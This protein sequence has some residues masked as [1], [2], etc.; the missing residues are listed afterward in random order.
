MRELIL[1]TYSP[2]SVIPIYNPNKAAVASIISFLNSLILY[3]YFI[4]IALYVSLE[5]VRVIQAQFIA[6]DIHMYDPI[7][8]K[9]AKVKSAGLNEELGQV[10]AIFSDKTGTL[11]CNQMDF[12]RVSIA[13][14]AYGI[15][16]TEV[17][18]AAKQLGIALGGGPS[19]RDPKDNLL[20]FSSDR[21]AELQGSINMMDHNNNYGHDNNP[22]REKGFTFYDP[23]LLG[24]N[25][26]HEPSSQN[27]QFFMQILAL[28]HTTIPDGIPK[29]PTSMRYRAESPDEAALVVAAKQFGFYFYKR[30]PTMLHVRETVSPNS[31]PVDQVYQLLNVLEFSIARKQMSVIVR[32]PNGRL[33][34]LSK[35]VDFVMLQRV[36]KNKSGF[37]KETNK[38]WKAFGEVGLRT[39]MVAYKQ[40]D[41]EEYTKWQA[42]YAEAR[43]TAGHER[44][45]RTEEL[46]DEIEQ[47]LTVAGGTGVED[48]LQ[49]GVPK[50]IDRFARAGIKIWVLTGD[51]EQKAFVGRKLSEALDL[52][53]TH[54][55]N[56]GESMSSAKAV[57]FNESLQSALSRSLSRTSTLS[58]NLSK[59]SGRHSRTPS[60]GT[61]NGF[62]MMPL[63]SNHKHTVGIGDLS[64]RL[65]SLG[66]AADYPLR[67]ADQHSHTIKYAL[68][69]D[70][71]SLAFILAEEELQE[72][73]LQVCIN[74]A[75]V[76]CYRVSPRQ[77]AQVTQLV[78]KG[79]GQKRLCV[80][81]GDGVYDVGMIQAT[82]VGVGIAGVEGAQAAMV[83]DYA[84]AQFR[85]LERLLLVHGRRCYR[86]ISLMDY[87]PKGSIASSLQEASKQTSHVVDR[88]MRHGIALGIARGMSFLHTQC[89]PPIVHGDVKPNNV[90]FDAD[91]E[92][93]LS[94][95]GLTAWTRTPVDP[96]PSSSSAGSLGYVSPEANESGKL[97]QEAD[98]YSFG[99]VL[100]EL[101]TRRRPAVFNVQDEDIAKRVKRMLQ[102]GEITEVFDP[103][104]VD[105]GPES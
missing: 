24:G 65:V 72:R 100:L 60:A 62:Q 30:T 83:A 92:P 68:V 33:L 103:A 48:K 104:S 15:G 69:I 37:V 91:L 39:L 84:I 78:R 10:D 16:T 74:R 38:H 41:E 59:H 57:S 35:G 8:N 56:L 93:H 58:R 73:F 13:G 3:G 88:P 36:D 45:L 75:S 19:P 7:T 66:D 21:K 11:T 67:K 81:I 77:K 51:K 6:T 27:I 32:F 101:P 96:T 44:D 2:P 12:F 18:R 95:F 102:L 50:A 4:P 79:L 80:A 85:F 99:M 5:I 52:V 22:Y 40:L 34:L 23:R 54:Q 29:D 61:Q 43:T 87:M 89:N 42:K 97:T 25:W 90:L 105:L 46:A 94:D 53:L 63:T 55:E 47:G 98:V 28:C 86:R 49:D 71:Q 26:I 1:G 70:G 14:V 20:Q 82:D 64:D 17:E 9:A 76:L 31:N